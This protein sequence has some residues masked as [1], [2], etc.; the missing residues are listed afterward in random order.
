MFGRGVFAGDSTGQVNITC[1]KSS[2]LHLSLSFG[3]RVLVPVKAPGTF[4]PS[5]QLDGLSQDQQLAQQQLAYEPLARI[6]GASAVPLDQQILSGSVQDYR[7]NLAMSFIPNGIHALNG[8]PL[9]GSIPNTAAGFP[10]APTA[11]VANE[12]GGTLL[13]R[14]AG[15][16]TCT[17][18]LP[19]MTEMQLLLKELSREPMAEDE[20]QHQQYEEEDQQLAAAEFRPPVTYYTTVPPPINQLDPHRRLVSAVSDPARL[21]EIRKRFDSNTL[22]QEEMDQIASELLEEIIY[23]SSDYIGPEALREVLAP[24]QD[25]HAR[26]LCAPSGDHRLPQERDQGGAED[27]RLC[28]QRRGDAA[29]LPEPASLRPPAPARL[30]WQLRDAMLSALWR[31]L[32][33]ILGRTRSDLR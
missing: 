13:D 5:A 10:L 24:D 2:Q 7:S 26:T 17:A 1:L 19:P 3:G 25:A 23:L 6:K 11:M 9:G 28:E 21:R 15:S 29:D 20:K 30:S 32:H 14:E 8:L 27:D 31:A 22:S 4:S 16:T 12:S 18:P 33:V